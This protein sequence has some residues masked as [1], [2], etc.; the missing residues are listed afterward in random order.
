MS[1]IEGHLK[2]EVIVD[3]V[4]GTQQ[5]VDAKSS[6]TMFRGFEL[7]LQGRDPLDAPDITQRICGVCPISHA[8]A[9]C[10]ALE[11]AAGI[12]PPKNGRLLRN[13][14]L[15]SNF[16]QSHVMHF[17][18][19]AALDYINTNG[20]LDTAPWNPKYTTPDM[21]TGTLADELVSHYTRALD[22]RRKAHQMAAVF[23]GKI[24]CSPSIVPGG[25]SEVPDMGKIHTFRLLL[26]EIQTFTKDVFIP[27]VQALADAF[28]NYYQIG[29]GCDNQ[30][31][32][33]V[34]EL[35]DT[36]Q[37]AKLFSAGR[38]TDGL[39][40]TVDTTAINEDVKYS[41]YSP[42]CEGLN[43]ANGL[44]EVQPGKAD[45]YSWIK[46]PR[47]QSVVHEAG[48]LARMKINGDY[49]G[50][51]SVMDRLMARALETEK[52]VDAM[53]GWLDEL[54]VDQSAYQ[55]NTISGSISGIGLCEAPRG[56]LGH[57]VQIHQNNISRYQVVTPTAWNMSP[58]DSLDQPGPLEQGLI[59]TP[60]ADTDHPIEVLRVVHSFDP[61]L[62]CSVHM[63]RP[64]KS[65][66]YL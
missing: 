28:P 14:I 4:D 19:L 15:G 44:T 53:L 27:D 41:W 57:W 16:I 18:H 43:P 5:V 12:T 59:G 6:G 23:G 62:A 13:L 45:A 9:S 29:G 33:G 3:T 55:P 66:K 46:A 42:N 56:A 17:Y 50:G 60:V 65:R 32:Y 48:P 52:L 37:P 2:V 38:I 35:D 25:C 61:C 20:I 10:L 40:E 22:I 11:Q 49:T 39:L 51:V 31:A 30:I 8:V 7:L 47:Y 63:L 54:D 64:G 1:R 36:P 21:L 34:F 24:P 26:T 58:K